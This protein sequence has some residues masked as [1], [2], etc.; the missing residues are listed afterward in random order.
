MIIN[1][2]GGGLAGSEAALQIARQGIDVFLYEMRPEKL[3]EAHKTSLF[4]ELVCS[5]SLGSLDMKDARGLLKEEAKNLGSLILQVAFKYSLPGGKALVVDREKFSKEITK[6]I[7]DNPRIKVKRGEVTNFPVDEINVIT[8]GPL[9][10]FDLLCNLKEKLGMTSLYF[11]DAI[12]PIVTK[13]SLDLSKMFYGA[14][15]T[16]TND[17]LN[18]PMTEEEYKTFYNA[19]INAEKHTPHDFD[20]VFFE[21]CLPVEEIAKRGF[22]S[23]RFGPLTP[24]GFNKKYHAIVQLRRENI[25]DTLYELVGFQTSLT[26]A[27]QKKVFRLIPGLENADFVRYGSIHKNSY[28]KSNE[29][30]LSTLQTKK[31]KNIFIAGQLCGVEGYT[32]STVT[33]LI[34]GVNAARL[35]KGK[36]LVSVPQDTML[37]SLIKFITQ[38]QL[39][40]PQPMRANFGLI[41]QE[42]F[43]INK[44]KRKE[45]FIEKSKAEIEKLKEIINE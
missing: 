36:E 22:D 42:Y 21:A 1:V 37:G 9:T 32:E 7:E 4:A 19:L 43:S 40:N 17:Y 39:Q 24:V 2:I 25:E 31:F 20:K 5:N 13:E 18:S 23:M 34:A 45:V 16:E 15:Y 8:T 38:N 28:V 10:S 26:Y 14:R 41:P 35:L 27:E 30:L 11:F 29:I 33:G 44:I 12:S 6:L 3:T